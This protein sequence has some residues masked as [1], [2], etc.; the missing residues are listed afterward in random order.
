M[1]FLFLNKCWS[2]KKPRNLFDVI[3]RFV[4]NCLIF[5]SLSIVFQSGTN[6]F[7]LAGLL[8]GLSQR[9]CAQCL[10]QTFTLNLLMRKSSKVLTLTNAICHK[11]MLQL[12][13]FGNS[14]HSG[15]EATKAFGTKGLLLRSGISGISGNLMVITAFSWNGCLFLNFDV[16]IGTQRLDQ[17]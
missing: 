11:D 13:R 12:P 9:A 14:Q 15:Q 17:S 16:S 1:L 8:G 6:H 2:V 10:W 3:M 7:S 4:A 5:P